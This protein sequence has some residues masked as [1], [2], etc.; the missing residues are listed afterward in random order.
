M[1]KVS[2]RNDV[3]GPY[4]MLAQREPFDSYGA[5]SAVAYAPSFTGRLPVDW[6]QRYDADNRNPGIVYTVRSWATPIAWIRAT[7]HVVIPD[8]S[9]SVS[10]TRHQNL[11]RTW[12]R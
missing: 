5:M 8:V 11:C 7:G 10:T 12:L 4:G 3:R 1:R 6:V 2:I 9:Y